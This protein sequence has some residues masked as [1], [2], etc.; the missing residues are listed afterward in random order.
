MVVNDPEHPSHVFDSPPSPPHG[1]RAEAPW[2]RFWLTTCM[3]LNCGQGSSRIGGEQ[4]PINSSSAAIGAIGAPR[5]H[6]QE[7]V[8]HVWSPAQTPVETAPE[9]VYRA[10]QVEYAHAPTFRRDA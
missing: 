1:A 2:R 5:P 8:R 7:R 10:E 3:P 6:E 4:S 9:V